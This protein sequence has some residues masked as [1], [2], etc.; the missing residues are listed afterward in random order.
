MIIIISDSSINNL[1]YFFQIQKYW[2]Y[3]INLSGMKTVWKKKI[4]WHDIGQ[5]LDN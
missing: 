3:L 1:E 2:F 4:H 5:T